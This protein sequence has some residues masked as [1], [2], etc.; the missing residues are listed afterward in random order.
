MFKVPIL[1]L[2]YNRYD[3]T[4]KSLNAIL[5]VKPSKLYISNDGPKLSKKDNYK[6][7]KI[8]IKY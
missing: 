4:K 5:K 6:V 2:S 1:L 8:I 3:F 7:L